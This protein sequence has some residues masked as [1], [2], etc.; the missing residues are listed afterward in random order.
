M[1][2]RRAKNPVLRLRPLSAALATLF[3]TVCEAPHAQAIVSPSPMGPSTLAVENCND[4][5]SGSLRAAIGIAVSGDT[6]DMTGLRCSTIS[7]T[8]GA[9]DVTQASLTFAGPG[10]NKLAIDGNNSAAIFYGS[11]DSGGTLQ[12]SGLSI[13]NGNLALHGGDALGACIHASGSVYLDH[14]DVSRCKASSDNGSALG[15]A[16]WAEESIRLDSSH[17]SGSSALTYGGGYASGGGLYSRGY[18]YVR[19]STVEENRAA[20]G[21]QDHSFGGGIFA[22]DNTVI[23]SSTI[24]SNSA[25]RS[26]GIDFG[27]SAIEAATII[28][29]TVSDNTARLIGGIFARPRLDLLNSTIAFNESTIAADSS[30]NH[31]AAGV[32]IS[33]PGAMESTIISEN[34]NLDPGS[35]NFDATGSAGAVFSG[36]H[37]NVM[38]CDG[39]CP[40]DTTNQSPGLM[41]LQDNGGPTRTH[42]P[43]PGD[44]D[45]FGGSNSQALAFD[46]RG[47]G[48]PRESVGDPIEIGAFQTNSGIIFVNGFN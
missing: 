38:A 9:L 23:I 6:I 36:A 1:T 13:V 4:S 26:G 2:T 37:N 39:I 28:S 40:A 7:L 10:R 11:G 34:I 42:A 5:G 30:G 16:I 32:H 33:Q 45:K 48:F 31:F 24:F 27:G 18:L 22:H 20:S 44:W 25:D 43:T 3:F 21:I 46:Q 35:P 14:V 41:P 29:S 17:V 15:G 12:L 47:P 19:N 8:T